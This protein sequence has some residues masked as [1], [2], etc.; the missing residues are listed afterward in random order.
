LAVVAVA[1]DGLD[2][3][4]VADVVALADVDVVVVAADASLSSASASSSSWMGSSMKMG[5][6]VLW[7]TF[8]TFS[9]RP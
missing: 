8:N 2:L 3:E 6:S 4:G 9:L 7:G 1:A 5:I